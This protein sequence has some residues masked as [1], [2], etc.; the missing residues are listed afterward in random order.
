MASVLEAEL[1]EEAAA[2]VAAA[3]PARLAPEAVEPEEAP[4][5]NRIRQTP[6]PQKLKRKGLVVF[7]FFSPVLLNSV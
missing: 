4:G 3:A 2:V 6:V 7:S 5:R 1:E